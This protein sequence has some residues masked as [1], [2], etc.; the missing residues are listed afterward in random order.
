MGSKLDHGY[1]SSKATLAFFKGLWDLPTN[2]QQ[3]R[4]PVC[5][6]HFILVLLDKL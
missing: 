1:E 2:Q 3:Q 6:L 5:N 4:R